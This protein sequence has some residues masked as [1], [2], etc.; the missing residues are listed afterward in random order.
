MKSHWIIGVNNS[1]LWIITK[2]LKQANV[3]VNF[4]HSIPVYQ[5]IKEV[6]EHEKRDHACIKKD[7]AT[8]GKYLI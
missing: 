4:V 8:P 2:I 7:D 6:C 5:S 3:N 1:K